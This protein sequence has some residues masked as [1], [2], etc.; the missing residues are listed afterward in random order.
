MRWYGDDVVLTVGKIRW[1][2]A[3]FRLALSPTDLYF[4][5]IWVPFP[6]LANS[7]VSPHRNP[8]GATTYERYRRV[9]W[10]HEPQA[11]WG[12]GT[13]LSLQIPQE[14]FLSCNREKS[15][16][17]ESQACFLKAFSSYTMALKSVQVGLLCPHSLNW[18]QVRGSC[19]SRQEV[20]CKSSNSD[21]WLDVDS[22]AKARSWRWSDL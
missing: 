11:R 18:V 21:I 8:W 16:S 14:R 10:E 22:R 3:N 4:I 2:Q 13:F 17:G 6:L 20:S 12:A 15:Q 5:L 9:T 19:F 7:G 1:S